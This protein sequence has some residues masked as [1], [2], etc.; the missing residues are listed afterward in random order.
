MYKRKTRDEY[1]IHSDYGYG[2]EF[3]C[4]GENLADAKRLLR[5]YRENEPEYT[6]KIVKVRVPIR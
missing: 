1:Q 4:C 2:Y 6:H 3:T 5:E